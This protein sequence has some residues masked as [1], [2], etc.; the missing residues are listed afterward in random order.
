M[1]KRNGF[2]SGAFIAELKKTGLF[3]HYSILQNLS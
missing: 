1:L 2:S 3:I